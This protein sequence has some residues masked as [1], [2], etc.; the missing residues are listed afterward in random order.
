MD[1][2]PLLTAG[3]FLFFLL[4][5]SRWSIP[6]SPSLS[7]CLIPVLSGGRL[8]LV[9]RKLIMVQLSGLRYAAFTSPWDRPSRIADAGFSSLLRLLLNFPLLAMMLL[10][11]ATVVQRCN[12]DHA[13]SSILHK[14]SWLRLS[15]IFLGGLE[16]CI[17]TGKVKVHSENFLVF[18]LFEI[19]NP[20]RSSALF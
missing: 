3:G 17:Q 7:V 18:Q 12:L 20:H 6:G 10:G 2:R 15:N 19:T 4:L 11:H 13:A 1:P 9:G 14:T 16:H 5:L 8:A